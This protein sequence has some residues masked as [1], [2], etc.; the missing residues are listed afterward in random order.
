VKRSIQKVVENAPLHVILR[1]GLF[2]HKAA[3]YNPFSVDSGADGKSKPK[4]NAPPYTSARADVL[5]ITFDLT[6]IVPCVT[7]YAEISWAVC[8]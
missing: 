4:V 1:L 8:T 6:K 5:P 3:R 2:E 7:R